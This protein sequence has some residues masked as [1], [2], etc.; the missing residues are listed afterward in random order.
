MAQTKFRARGKSGIR[1]LVVDIGGSGI[2]AL[3]LDSAGGAL[4]ARSP[5]SFS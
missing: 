2:K 5:G 4:T 1:T 3:A